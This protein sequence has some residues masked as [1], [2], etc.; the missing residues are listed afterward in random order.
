MAGERDRHTDIID[1]VFTVGNLLHAILDHLRPYGTLPD[2]SDL[3]FVTT[4]P[5]NSATKRTKIFLIIFGIAILFLASPVSA[6]GTWNATCGNGT[7]LAVPLPSDYNWGLPHH[8]ATMDSCIDYGAGYDENCG[9]AGCVLENYY[10]TTP[11]DDRAIFNPAPWNYGGNPFFNL[12]N[13]GSLI[14][15]GVEYTW[16]KNVS[17][18]E[19]VGFLQKTY[20][21]ES[22]FTE[23]DICPP[24]C[25]NGGTFCLNNTRRFSGSGIVNITGPTGA[26]QIFSVAP[27]GQDRSACFDGPGVYRFCSLNDPVNCSCYT[28][29][30]CACT[31]PITNITNVCIRASIDLPN[32]SVIRNNTGFVVNPNAVSG[33]NDTWTLPRVGNYTL[34]GC[35]GIL[36]GMY[37]PPTPTPTPTPTPAPCQGG[38]YCPGD[39]V[40]F[41]GLLDLL[42]LVT[43]RDPQGAEVTDTLIL[44]TQSFPAC[45]SGA[46]Q[47]TYNLNILWPGCYVCTSDC[48]TP[49]PTPTPTGNATPTPTPF[50]I[51][52]P[53]TGN[54][55]LVPVANFTSNV[56]SGTAPLAV[57]FNDTSTNFPTNWSWRFGDGGKNR[58]Q[59]PVHTYTL[60]GRYN[61]TLVAANDNGADA[62]VKARYV[63]V[64]APQTTFTVFA[65]GVSQYHG[66]EGNSDLFRAKTTA[67]EFY[68][69]ISGKQGDPYSSI[70]W[71]GI[72][73]PVD[74][75]TGL[76]N[77]N[78][79]EDANSMANNAD[80]AVHAGHGWNE[81][82]LFGTA[83]PDYEL[84]RT[85]NLSFGGNNGKAKWVAL[86]SCSVLNEGNWQ[87]W[88]SVFNGLHILMGFDTHGIEGANQGLQF[89][90]RMT[91]DGLYPAPYK[92]RDAW[93]KT[94]KDTINDVSIKGAYM[95]ADPSS[96]D[97]LPGFGSFS[98]PVK[99]SNGQYTI[100]WI[101]FTCE[102]DW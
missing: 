27:V 47:Y 102:R 79:N 42:G 61:V 30:N 13:G 12:T 76:R 52:F 94:L 91:G 38:T 70:H 19:K 64:T 88:T 62:E 45:P 98:E 72:G 41:S 32:G 89:A 96:E 18:R 26:R 40:T 83:N 14:I 31:E 21:L 80:F 63:N 8:D 2:G 65:D 22:F 9:M 5:E 95:Y 66:Y 50:V 82:I 37:C 23:P 44:G 10:T 4:F 25:S 39:S 97:F 99:D 24:T 87:N 68:T 85:N 55:D 90:Q 67:E 49:T 17:C 33:M 101:S 20:I 75:S 86:F 3:G 36:R 28:C 43:I 57:Q 15:V 92:I 69:N 35:G 60:A 100:D 78:I 29:G 53:T 93:K 51:T 7:F 34:N 16:E 73:N 1:P 71:V 74:D 77:W 54:P 56:T 59:N 48:P 84:F 6:V 81:G 11:P 46:G 58:T